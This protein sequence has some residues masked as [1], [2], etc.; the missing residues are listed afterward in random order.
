MPRISS[1]ASSLDVI[2]VDTR[3]DFC[4]VRSVCSPAV[5]FGSFLLVSLLS[6]VVLACLNSML[7]DEMLPVFITYLP[8]NPVIGLYHKKHNSKNI[9]S[10]S[11]QKPVRRGLSTFSKPMRNHICRQYSKDDCSN[12]GTHTS[13]GCRCIEKRQY[14]GLPLYTYLHRRNHGRKEATFFLSPHKSN[15]ALLCLSDNYLLETAAPFLPPFTIKKIHIL[16]VKQILCL[17]TT[18]VISKSWRDHS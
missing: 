1:S 4:V 8:E 12:H 9:M 15:Y 5:F 16:V 3:D 17:H 13:I 18:A 6:C 2:T 14:E 11:K 10:F 7:P